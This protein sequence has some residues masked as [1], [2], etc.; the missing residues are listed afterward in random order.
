MSASI[1][2]HL[3]DI[4]RELKHINGILSTRCTNSI[5]AFPK[6]DEAMMCI[7]PNCRTTFIAELSSEYKIVKEKTE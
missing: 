6:G 4:A 7:C 3:K 2:N 5:N 1:E